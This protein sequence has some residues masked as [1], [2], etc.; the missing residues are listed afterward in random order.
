MN[1]LTQV[2]YKSLTTSDATLK[3]IREADEAARIITLAMAIIMLT[4][5]IDIIVSTSSAWVF[6]TKYIFGFT[7]HTFE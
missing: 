6:E 1:S 3:L 7:R 4:S 2:R 5:H